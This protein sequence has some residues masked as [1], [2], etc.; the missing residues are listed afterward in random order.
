MLP[1]LWNEIK[2]HGKVSP[3]RKLP[4][5]SHPLKVKAKDILHFAQDKQV[6]G[7]TNTPILSPRWAGIPC[8]FWPQMLLASAERAEPAHPK[9]P[10]SS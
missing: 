10:L 6:T 2:I 1:T 3:E 8:P 9:K 5:C 4:A 7:R